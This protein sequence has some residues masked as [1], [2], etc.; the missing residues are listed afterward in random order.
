[1]LGFGD[2]ATEIYKMINPIE[3]SLTKEACDKYRVEPYV[4][5]ADVYGAGN[6]I[7]RGGWTWYTGSS[8][9]YYKAGI[10]YLLGLKIEEGFL[11]I[12]PCIPKNWEKYQIQYKWKDSVYNIKIKNP[13]GKSV[14]VT[15]VFLDGV[16][17]K[18]KIKLDGSKNIYNVEVIM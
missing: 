2:K 12:D 14:G 15:K 13:K 1:M 17:V 11:I 6:L 18:N 7:G 8:S 10:E 16:E 5:A 9:W 4:M 3:H